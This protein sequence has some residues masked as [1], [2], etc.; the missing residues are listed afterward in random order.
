[1]LPLE[2]IAAATGKATSPTTPSFLLVCSETFCCMLYVLI[3]IIQCKGTVVLRWGL[4]I[5]SYFV[6]LLIQVTHR[7]VQF[8]NCRAWFFNETISHYM[9][10]AVSFSRFYLIFKRIFWYILRVFPSDKLFLIAKVNLEW[11]DD[12]NYEPISDLWFWKQIMW[13]ILS[14]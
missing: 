9:K 4:T 13:K 2:Y 14:S 3:V 10:I 12:E 11:Y 1:M 8:L 6:Q 5:L 7:T